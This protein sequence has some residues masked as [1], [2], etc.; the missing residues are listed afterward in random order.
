LYLPLA[1]PY[2]AFPLYL[3]VVV[4]LAWASYRCV[5]LPFMNL[6]RGKPRHA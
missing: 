4:P 3:A 5:E 2:I 6:R 1:P